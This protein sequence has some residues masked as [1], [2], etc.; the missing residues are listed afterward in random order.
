MSLNKT[1]I[2]AVLFALA[3]CVGGVALVGVTDDSDAAGET[4]TI[5][6]V[7]EGTTYSYTGAEA[8]VVLKSIEDIGATIPVGKQMDGWTYLVGETPVM[9]GVGSTV[10]LTAGVA[11]T[12]TAKLSTIEYTV[13][14]M[15]G[16]TVISTA[17]YTYDT[18]IEVP[19]D[20]VKEGYTFA[21]WDPAVP[22]TVSESAEFAATWTEIFDVTWTVEGVNVAF[23]TTENAITLNV[24]A[25]PVKD[26]Y[27]F[28]GWYDADGVKY[29]TAYEFTAD[30]IF[31]AQFAANVYTVT[32]VYG[33]E[34]TVYLTETVQ[35]GDKAVRPM[36]L[37]EGYSGWDFDFETPVT[38]DLT[39]TATESEPGAPAFWNTALGQCAIIIAVFLVGLVAWA[40]YTGK[41]ELPKVKITRGKQE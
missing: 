8:S 3:L 14:F 25:D 6:Y 22:E 23:G 32:F 4:Y 28:L 24:P 9:V 39:I 31:S 19:A 27:R 12:F 20:P 40:L 18:A 10:V 16:E 26:S 7:V 38:E 11:T 35:H 41:I 13:V 30:T 34:S 15:D 37:P 33:S 5:Q 21:G 1:G 2:F 17:D 29:D 36:G